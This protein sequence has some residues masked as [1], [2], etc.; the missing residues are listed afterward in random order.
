MT[1]RLA[2]QHASPQAL[3]LWSLRTLG[4]LIRLYAGWM[5]RTSYHEADVN[6]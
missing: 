1:L 6:V 5:V 3:L 4:T 2:L